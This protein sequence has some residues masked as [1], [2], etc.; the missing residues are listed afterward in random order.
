MESVAESVASSVK[1]I[2]IVNVP[3][4]TTFDNCFKADIEAINLASLQEV[5][6]YHTEKSSNNIMAGVLLNNS[7]SCQMELDTAASQSMIPYENFQKLV[8]MCQQQGISPPKLEKNT[9]IMRQ[10]DGTMS[11]LVKGCTYL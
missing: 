9:V 4:V 2:D 8:S 5:K 1:K 3:K 11:N 7:L 6:V 10:A